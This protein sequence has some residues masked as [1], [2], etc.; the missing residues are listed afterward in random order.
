MVKNLFCC[1]VSARKFHLT[2]SCIYFECSFLSVSWKGN[3][4]EE[5]MASD[6]RSLHTFG[7]KPT[8]I[9]GI[10][11]SQVRIFIRRRLLFSLHGL[12]GQPI[13]GRIG[14]SVYEL[15]LGK[16]KRLAKLE[17]C[18]IRR[19]SAFPSSTASIGAIGY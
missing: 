7:R 2:F 9:L 4:A 19:L 3:E 18:M 17:L 11:V 8:L 10:Q 12:K 5:I 16:E 14:L 15:Y 6:L 13:D 1:G